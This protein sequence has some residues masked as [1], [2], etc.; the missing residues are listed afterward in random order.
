MFLS[1]GW[2]TAAGWSIAIADSMSG[3]CRWGVEVVD[4]KKGLE[5]KQERRVWR[6]GGGYLDCSRE[7]EGKGRM[8]K[9]EGEAG[10]G[11]RGDR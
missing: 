4:E 8:K 7:M 1:V 2:V 3:G 6:G 11:V 9:K 10:G 5:K